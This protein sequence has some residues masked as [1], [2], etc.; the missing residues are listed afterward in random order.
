MGWRYRTTH[1][2]GGEELDGEHFL[3]PWSPHAGKLSISMLSDQ[4]PRN[5]YSV[6]FS[7]RKIYRVK[8]FEHWIFP[9]SSRPLI[10]RGTDI[11]VSFGVL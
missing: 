3:R 8:Y 1:G 2:V 6:I 9:T 11:L 7:G 4:S 5:F 10:S